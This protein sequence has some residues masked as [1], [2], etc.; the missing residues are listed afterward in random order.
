MLNYTPA[1]WY[2]IV[3]GD[4]SQVYASALAAY[5]ATDDPDFTVW[6]EDG[7]LPTKIASEAE[8]GDVLKAAGV[9]SPLAK[10]F[11]T[12]TIRQFIIALAQAGFI[13]PAEAL[14]AATVRTIPAAI[15]AVFSG[16]PA[17]QKL[18]AEITFGLM[19]QV[20]RNEPLVAACAASMG[21]TDAQVDAFF[22]NAAGI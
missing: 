21:L 3:A 14:A 22:T 15:A 12:L 16:L 13:T 19:T 2:W 1:N 20:S 9:A 4:A 8:L 17:D 6:C 11:P 10:V 5:V 18:G 7:N